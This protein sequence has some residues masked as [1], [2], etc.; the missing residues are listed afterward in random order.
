MFYTC[1]PR[2][3]QN[4]S[5]RTCYVYGGN[6]WITSNENAALTGR[7]LTGTVRSQPTA[8]QERIAEEWRKPYGNTS[9]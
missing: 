7:P 8:A 9:R 2:K 1:D 6:C 5:K 3:N 4:C